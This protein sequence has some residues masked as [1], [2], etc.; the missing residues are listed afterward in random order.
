MTGRGRPWPAAARNVE[1]CGDTRWRRT[2]DAV[3]ERGKAHN[4][5][6]AAVAQGLDRRD[7]TRDP[8][9]LRRMARAGL[10]GAEPDRLRPRFGSKDFAQRRSF[11]RIAEFRAGA[12][13]FDI[14]DRVGIDPAA[15][16]RVADEVRLGGGVGVR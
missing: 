5:G 12:V 9:R 16:Q 2:A 1:P 15:L 3:V 6:Q 7:E 14:V 8:G 11:D 4:R 10:D 13:R